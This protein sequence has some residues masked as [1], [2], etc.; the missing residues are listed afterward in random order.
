MERKYFTL[1]PLEG[2][3]VQGYALGG[4]NSSPFLTKEDTLNLIESIESW[5]HSDNV[6]GHY[7]ENSDHFHFNKDG[8]V[9]VFKGAG[10]T[11]DSGNQLY[12][13]G[14]EGWKWSLLNA[15]KF[16]ADEYF[17]GDVVLAYTKDGKF[18]EVEC[19]VYGEESSYY[20]VLDVYDD[21]DS[22]SDHAALLK[23]IKLEKYQ[24][25]GMSVSI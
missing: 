9:E 12:Q 20:W 25:V 10:I 5:F 18:L 3:L 11:D 4:Q 15:Q 23:E 24:T 13:I 1:D 19:W 21:N 16:N 8:A 14:S 22:I 6:K 2:V 17:L 7:D